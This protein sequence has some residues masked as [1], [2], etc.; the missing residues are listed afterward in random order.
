MKPISSKLLE[1][2][3]RAIH[4]AEVLLREGDID[5]AAGRIYYAMFYCAKAMLVHLGLI[6]FTKHAA[7]HAAYGENFAKTQLLE[8]KFHRWLI[9]SFDKRL[10]ADY[11]VDDV[12]KLED[13]ELMIQQAHEFLDA[14]RQYLMRLSP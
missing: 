13:V 5:F 14:V 9:Q 8:P 6:E 4:A 1:K 11:D 2:A 12:L 3:S 7:V 10:K